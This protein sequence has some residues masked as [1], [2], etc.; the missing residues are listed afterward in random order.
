MRRKSIKR[1]ENVAACAF[2]EGLDGAQEPFGGCVDR[3]DC[4]NYLEKRAGRIDGELGS[5]QLQLIVE[6]GEDRQAEIVKAEALKRKQQIDE[7]NQ[8]LTNAPTK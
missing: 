8:M 6:A 2:E 7:A 4:S 5:T 1:C 3:S